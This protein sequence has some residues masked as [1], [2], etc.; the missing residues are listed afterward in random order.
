MTAEPTVNF[1]QLSVY[2]RDLPSTS[3]NFLH[4]CRTFREFPS[5]FSACTGPSVS[6]KYFCGTFH[7][8]PSTFHAAT[9]PSFNFPCGRGTFCQFSM[10]PRDHS[11]AFRA[12]W[13]HS[14]N[15]PTLC[16]PSVNFR[17]FYVWLR[18]LPSTFH[19]SVRPVNLLCSCGTFRSLPST[20]RTLAGPSV[21]YS[22]LFV[23]LREL[24]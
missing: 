20:F 13:G 18:D 15:L 17:Q 23:H 8:V 24:P 22:Q 19:A 7:Q 1:H 4:V 14:M 3:V 2:P 16:A 6:F 11:S 12:A 21:N 10:R 9:R 5:A